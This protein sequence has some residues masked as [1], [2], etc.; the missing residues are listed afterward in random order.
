MKTERS[1]TL[2]LNKA[3]PRA[4]KSQPGEDI[5]RVLVSVQSNRHARASEVKVKG[6]DHVSSLQSLTK[7][8]LPGTRAFP[9]R[10]VLAQFAEEKVGL[11]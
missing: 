7:L 9:K 11:C 5:K 10:R 6:Y 4:S 2:A 1:C 8:D 3:C